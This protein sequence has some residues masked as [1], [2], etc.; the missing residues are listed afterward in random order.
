MVHT[1]SSN[2]TQSMSNLACYLIN[3]KIDFGSK[4]LI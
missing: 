4:L 3:T 2:Y 1:K